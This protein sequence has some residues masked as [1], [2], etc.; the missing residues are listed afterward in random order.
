MPS[1][2]TLSKSLFDLCIG[3]TRLYTGISE[4]RE[5][6]IQLPCLEEQTKIANFLSSLDQKIEI[7]AQQIEQAK[8]WKKGLLQQIFV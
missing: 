5:L 7:V 1:N 8:T 6:P 3:A 4:Q 2:F